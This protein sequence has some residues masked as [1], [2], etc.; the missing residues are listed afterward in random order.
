MILNAEDLFEESK[1]IH[2]IAL[3]SNPGEPSR[4]YLQ[5]TEV[6]IEQLLDRMPASQQELEQEREKFRLQAEAEAAKYWDA[7]K[8][9][10]QIGA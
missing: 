7:L 9:G 8:A 4:K 10:E 3:G 2:R 1:W 5:E 6:Q